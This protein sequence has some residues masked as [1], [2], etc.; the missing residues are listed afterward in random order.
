MMTFAL[1]SMSLSTSNTKELEGGKMLVF[2]L[3]WKIWL[4]ALYYFPIMPP[5]PQA[6]GERR[7]CKKA[8]E[9]NM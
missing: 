5:V 7:V 1:P 2:L 6:T 8:V 3:T 9:H 4:T